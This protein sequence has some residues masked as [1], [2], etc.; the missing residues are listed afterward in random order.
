MRYNYHTH[1]ARCGHASGT[2]EEYILRAIE[3]GITHMGFS[4]HLP[5]RFP[6]GS[7]S[8]YRIPMEQARDYMDTLYALREKYKDQIQ[9]HIGFEMEYYPSFFPAMLNTAREL[10]AEYL[11]LGQHFTGDEYPYDNNFYV[12]LPTDDPALLDEYVTNVLTAMDTG[13]F[14]YVAHPDLFMKRRCGLSVRAERR[15]IRRTCWS[16]LKR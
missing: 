13:L 14:T 9:L 16:P 7:Q 6:N 10:G 12:V 11:L 2:E 1:T 3:G 4:D 15:S 8:G 5:A